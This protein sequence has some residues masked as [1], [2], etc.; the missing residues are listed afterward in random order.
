MNTLYTQKFGIPK[1]LE[2][3]TAPLQ[4]HALNQF[5]A[6]YYGEKGKLNNYMI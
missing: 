5:P 3:P 1:Y 4:R 2:S 6:P